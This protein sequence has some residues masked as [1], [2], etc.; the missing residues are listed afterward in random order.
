M[1]TW[2]RDRSRDVYSGPRF[3]KGSKLLWVSEILWCWERMGMSEFVKTS[4]DFKCKS[5]CKGQITCKMKYRESLKNLKGSNGGV[6]SLIKM[7]Y[8]Y[9]WKECNCVARRDERAVLQSWVRLRL[10][11]A[12]PQSAQAPSSSCTSWTK[13]SYLSTRQQDACAGMG[14][15]YKRP[16]TL[17]L[18]IIPLK[19]WSL[20]NWNSVRNRMPRKENV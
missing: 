17:S 9:S 5:V 1:K 3:E 7:K 4:S 13:Q 8:L 11:A 20:R 10:S 2:G 16:V 19:Q 6:C 14:I 15:F 12:A 18:V